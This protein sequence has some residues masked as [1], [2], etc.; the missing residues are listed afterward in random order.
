[1]GNMSLAIQRSHFVVMCGL[2]SIAMSPGTITVIG[3]APLV[4]RARF[5]AGLLKVSGNTQLKMTR[6][7]CKDTASQVNFYALCMWLISR[8]TC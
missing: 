4:S 5:D 7:L 6:R 2:V 1:M 8:N 3:R